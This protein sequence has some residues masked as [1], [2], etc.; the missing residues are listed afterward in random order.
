MTK[1]APASRRGR[2]ASGR[3]TASEPKRPAPTSSARR[4]SSTK[5]AGSATR[6]EPA[7]SKRS[8][9]KLA[10][11]KGDPA[12]LKRSQ[13][14]TSASTSGKP[15]EP[16]ERKRAP[17]KP[18][19]TSASASAKRAEP[20][21]AAFA[22]RSAPEDGQAAPALALASLFARPTRERPT[23]SPP[24]AIP[25]A[26]E[27]TPAELNRATLARQLLL[28]RSALSP[29][30][31]I[32]RLVALQAQLAKPPFVGLW[33]R[34]ADFRRDHLAQ[35]LRDRLAVRATT[36]RGTLHIMSAS[37]YAAFRL[38]LQPMLT[39]GMQSI[40]RSRGATL[41]PVKLVAAAR[42]ILAAAPATF[43]T[44]RD[45]LVAR[46]PDGND[47]AMGY[48]VRTLVPLI[49][50]PSDDRWAFPGAASFS[51]WRGPLADGD[52]RDLVRRYLAAFGPATA[53]DA[54]SWS[55]VSNLK[56]IFD[57]LRAELVTFRA[58]KRELFDL[59]DAPRPPGDTPAPIRFLPDFDNLVLGHADRAR[60]LDDAH[61]AAV[62]TKN[63]QV[64]ATFLVDGRVAGTWTI[65]RKQDTATVVL[66]P[67]QPIPNKLRDA[68]HAEAEAVAR[69]VEDDA[70][71]Y[72]VR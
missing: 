67:F 55:G 14:A 17:A 62:V 49:Q 22:T 10:S 12:G 29:L 30:A 28:E 23:T 25:G 40:L 36:L 21:E 32:E 2:S 34:L 69:F 38:A 19:A 42:E 68:V 71:D 66:A 53:A 18:A 54:Q 51:L 57:E 45:R 24:I 31:A 1:R 39:A 9:A 41:D 47:R 5:S 64:K 37:D 6:A 56:P 72:A 48:A 11:A 13:A 70:T 59:P 65:E 20:A 35:L 60:L 3:A 8:P 61:R 43:D 50:V 63:L 58:G 26:R 33:T 4:A 27:L 7:E 15:G 16:A 52:L 44:I 46:F